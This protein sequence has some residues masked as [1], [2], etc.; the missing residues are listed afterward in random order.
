MK[1]KKN[2]KMKIKIKIIGY[3][4][5][6]YQLIILKFKKLMVKSSC[7]YNIKF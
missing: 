1:R 2:Y 3:N 6:L 7:T 5:F 4:K